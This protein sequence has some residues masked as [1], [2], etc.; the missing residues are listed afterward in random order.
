MEKKKVA[1]AAAFSV[2]M[3]VT[4][5]TPILLTNAVDSS[6]WYTTIPGVL[7]SD[8]Y[9]LYP[10]AKK[11]V[12][13]GFSKFGE[14][15]GIPATGN[16]S[17]QGQ[18]V[19]LEYDTRDP[20]TPYD[21]VPMSSWINGWY[22]RI[23]YIS[24]TATNK[25]RKL[26]AFA[27]FGDGSGWGGDWEYAT[28]P[29]QGSGGRQ[30]NGSCTTD[31]LKV[32]YN[33]PRR[34][35]AQ[36]VTHISDKE[37]A[38]TW[39][40]LDLTVT[41][42][43]DK[44]MKQVIL[45]KD[46]KVT[47]AKMN[48][49]DKLDVQLSNREQ[50]DLGPATGYSSYAHYYEQEGVTCLGPDW[51]M[52]KNLTRDYEQHTT[53]YS[54]QRYFALSPPGSAPLASGFLKIYDDNAFV[55]PSLTPTPY[56]INWANRSVYFTTPPAA[57]SDMKFVYK[58]VFK[59]EIEGQREGFH[60]WNHE[61]D[62][63]QVISSDGAYIA[64]DGL[65]PPVSDFTVDGI[66]NFLYPLSQSRVTDMSYEPKQS[67]LII[68]EWD[69]LLDHSSIPMFRAVEV[70][71][72]SD[73]HDANDVQY[74][75]SNYIDREARYQLDTV[76]QAWDLLDAVEKQEYRS[77]YKS[78]VASHTSEIQLTTQLGD[79][80][81]Y[82]LLSSEYTYSLG[83]SSPTWTRYFLREEDR[84]NDGYPAES[85]W[86]N[87][88]QNSS[89]YADTAHS[90][91]WALYMV[92]GTY[93]EMVKVTPIYLRND[94][95]PSTGPYTLQLKD[96]VDFGFW[97]KNISGSLGPII[98]IKLYQTAAGTGNWANI[99]PR[100]DNTKSAS[101][102]T[103]YTLNTIDDFIGP[104]SPDAAFYLTGQSGTGLPTNEFHSFEYWTSSALKDYYV[105]SIGVKIQ[106]NCVALVD[107]LSV[108]YLQRP[109]GIRYERVYNMEEDKLVPHAWDAYCTFSEEV[110]VDGALI[111]RY[112]YQDYD[113][114]RAGTGVHRPYYTMN[115]INGTLDFY[116]WSTGLGRYITWDLYGSKVEIRYSTIEEN[117][118]GRYEWTVMGRDAFT[119]DSLGGALVTAAFKNKDIEIGL[120]G[121]DM[122]YNEW[123]MASIP[124]AMNCFG[125][126]PGARGDY[127]DDGSTPGQR[128]ALRGDWCTTWAITSSD[129][130]AIGGPLANMLTS[131]LNEFTDAFYGTYVVGWGETYTSYA[132]WQNAIVALTCWN[133]TKKGYTATYN[134]GYAVISTY[135]DLNGTVGLTIWG[136]GPRDTYYASKF[137]HEEIIY[138]LQTFPSCVTSIILKIDYTYPQ[139]PTFTVLECLGTV[140]E[141]RVETT[142]GGIHDP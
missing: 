133:G 105:G 122:M 8:Y 12:K 55:N 56:A 30:T 1:I 128:P 142:K 17:I 43:F 107:D 74:Q 25:D 39:P 101:T 44:D 22:I 13:V 50:Y 35:V 15:I 124:Y 109:S 40:V 41:L 130:I 21:T 64:W 106:A 5:L 140:S 127:K 60:T 135:K 83:A 96:L 66:L 11:S 97:Y 94:T 6:T 52:A 141:R 92:G 81:Y 9:L 110:T 14:L 114:T 38:T 116:Q 123:S 90:K 86:V 134:T 18:W 69:F 23:D 71:G 2:I 47:I 20:F 120:S 111:A 119:S 89:I 102:W 137:F 70:K 88:F 33:G 113:P 80:L 53:S 36:S 65:W 42:I 45:L 67:P 7:D 79:D 73:R 10:F 132:T 48:L 121:L 100:A 104:Y 117:E 87:E 139:H 49:Y 31:A 27:M 46:V 37:G 131:Y 28:Q 93:G 98:E 29:G 99:A 3:L 63:A 126:A 19:G 95:P 34:Y 118:K 138:E 77:L 108:A 91:N 82:C 26:F 62:I 76:F 103:H 32:L 112:G 72:I 136:H 57:G 4:I 85:K 59:T 75:G 129:T 115:F 51:H 24:P 84:S 125:T 58:Y 16:Q 78:T 68:G 54:G 61:Y